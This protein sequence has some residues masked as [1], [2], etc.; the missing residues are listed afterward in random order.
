ME[1]SRK[2][3]TSNIELLRILMM[4]VIV[5]HHY[6]VNSGITTYIASE[7]AYNI[8]SKFNTYFAY[9][10]GSGGKIAINV[11][12]LI[13]GYYSC[14]KK[15]KYKKIIFFILQVLFYRW[16]IYLIF[17][18]SGYEAFSLKEFVKVCLEIP[19]LLGKGFTSSYIVL[20]L[21]IPYLNLFIENISKKDLQ[22]LIG[23]LLIVFS[24]VPSISFNTFFEYIGWYVTVYFIGSYIRLYPCEYMTNKNKI[25]LFCVITVLASWIS[26]VI[27]IY[28]SCKFNRHLPIYWFVM[29]SNKIMAILTATSLFIL[30]LNID[31]GSKK[32]INIIASSTFGV[33]L[34]HANS[35]TMRRWLWQDVC[36]NVR[37]FQSDKFVIHAII[38]TITV[39]FVCVCIDLLRKLL[40]NLFMKVYNTINIRLL[41]K[42][43]YIGD[44]NV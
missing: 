10:Y 19:Y 39:Y 36:Q 38:F 34:I 15:I 43:I 18:L 14:K 31:I 1:N 26:I 44:K 27:L 32:I 40:V 13:T 22:K 37:F 11:F 42:S 9:L 29:D 4:L 16:I 30:F 3:R 35:D 41:H 17:Y 5:A 6:I 12:L 33:L 21:L 20:F 7:N 8:F 24:I 28:M 23:L 2:E 25:S